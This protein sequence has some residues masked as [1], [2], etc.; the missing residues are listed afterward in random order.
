MEINLIHYVFLLTYLL[1][2]LLTT[3]SLI[4]HQEACLIYAKFDKPFY[5]ILN[6]LPKS[7]R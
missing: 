1:T 3:R 6:P 2:Y 7:D 5:M 4:C